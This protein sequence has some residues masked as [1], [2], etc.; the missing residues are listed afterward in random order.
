MAYN[1]PYPARI[2]EGVYGD[3]LIK[4]KPAFA[5]I[6]I[7]E[8]GWDGKECILQLS[9]EETARICFEKFILPYE[10]GEL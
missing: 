6:W 5:D 7:I 4:C 1:N 2:I 10:E 8:V 3:F 9:N